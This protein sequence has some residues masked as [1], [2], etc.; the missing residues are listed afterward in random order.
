MLSQFSFMFLIL[1]LKGGCLSRRPKSSIHSYPIVKQHKQQ[2]LF[3]IYYVLVLL[4]FFFIFVCSCFFYFYFLYFILGNVVSWQNKTGIIYVKI[5]I[6]VIIMA[7]LILS[8]QRVTLNHCSELITANRLVFMRLFVIAEF[9][10]NAFLQMN[11]ISLAAD[12]AW[13]LI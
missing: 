6:Y 4:L 9:S 3:I 10:A 7:K 11:C 12:R 1:S 8:P 5:D 2:Q 13:R